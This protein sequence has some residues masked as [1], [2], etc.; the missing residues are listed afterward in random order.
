[1]TKS[2]HRYWSAQFDEV[3]HELS[4]LM[5]ACDIELGQPDLAERTLKDD[6]SVCRRSNPNAFR[7]IRTHLMALFPLE[8]RALDRL[9]ADDTQEILDDVREAIRR[10]RDAGRS[11]PSSDR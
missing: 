1:M 6:D 4:K 10:L 8:V 11:A 2:R 5:I 3:A 7:K 9:G